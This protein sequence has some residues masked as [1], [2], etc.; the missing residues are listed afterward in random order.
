MH[1]TPQQILL[2]REST[3]DEIAFAR[4]L[5][6]FVELTEAQL[7]KEAPVSLPTEEA[8]SGFWQNLKITYVD[9]N[10]TVLNVVRFFLEHKGCQVSIFTDPMEAVVSI[11]ETPPDLLLLDIEMPD[12]DGTD[13][14][15]VIRNTPEI[16]SLPVIFVTGLLGDDEAL[17]KSKT[18]KEKYISKPLTRDKLLSAI[19]EAMVQ[20]KKQ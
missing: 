7:T 18:G 10:E 20:F 1:L 14:L 4:L 2:I 9:D 11:R 6:L 13:T 17:E 15:H 5:D 19:E 3:K 8:P 12:M 16:Q